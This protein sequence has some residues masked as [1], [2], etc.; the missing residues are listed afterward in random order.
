M[1]EIVMFNMSSFREWEKG[2]VNRNYHIF[3][4]LL[5]RQEVKRVIAVDFLPFTIK[6][7]IKNYWKNIIHGHKGQTIYRDLTTKC[8]KIS[9]YPAELYIFSTIDSI[10][11]H[12]LVIKKIN[13]VLNKISQV[14]K[15]PSTQ[16]PRI[17]WSYFPMFIKYFDDIKSDITVFDAVDNWIEHPSFANF[18][19]TLKKNYQTIADKSDIIFTVA[20]PLLDFFK[21]FGREKNIHWIP[22]G[23]DVNRF[24]NYKSQITN[25]KSE[26]LNLKS[27]I[28][29]PIIGYVGTIQNR[30]DIDLLEYIAK[31]N[32]EKS[33]VFI[34]PVWKGVEIKRLKKYKNIYLLG[35]KP[36]DLVPLYIKQ[37]DICIIPHKLDEFIKYTYSLKLIEFLS[38][39]KPVVTFKTPETKLFADLIYAADDYKDFNKKLDIALKS[40]TIEMREK[41]IERVK[42]EDWRLKVNEMIKILNNVL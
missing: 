15:Y 28:K 35:R 42:T 40:D 17:I 2:V 21:I 25:Q 11:S 12:K 8:T 1:I 14:P 16:V 38:C 9:G 27:K 5:Q 37:F 6:R 26:I 30:V 13:K 32:P 24:T 31:N 23:V 18:K 41:R 36:H 10:F 34:G 29:E 3:N 20:E 7:A 39:G 33:F 4:N 22:N 19:H